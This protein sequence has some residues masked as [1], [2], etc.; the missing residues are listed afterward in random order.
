MTCQKRPPSPACLGPGTARACAFCQAIAQKNELTKRLTSRQQVVE[1]VYS[2]EVAQL[3]DGS[4]PQWNVH[5]TLS[6]EPKGSVLT[7]KVLVH[8]VDGSGAATASV[9][10]TWASMVGAVW[11]NK[12]QLTVPV[13]DT[14]M[15]VKAAETLTRTVAFTLEWTDSATAHAYDVTCNKSMTTKEFITHFEGLPA[16]ERADLVAWWRQSQPTLRDYSAADPE[17]K[18]M[19]YLNDVPR[20]ATRHGTPH[21]GE[22]GDKDREAVQ[23]E[24]G[25]AI[26]LPDEYLT[27]N[28]WL[29]DPGGADFVEVPLDLA[30]YNLAPFSSNSLM[31]NTMSRSGSKLFSR[32]FDLLAKDFEDLVRT[33]LAVG[34]HVKAGSARV[35]MIA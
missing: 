28:Y 25:H 22:W 7:V 12:A 5:Y 11:N 10:G 32:H 8:V 34:R 13:Y 17:W 3:C 1:K 24:F 31:N 16:D 20:D 26:G 6:T 14:A 15:A 9:R 19:K 27:T 2:R 23:H 35:Q 21:I 30:I 4:M 18:K 33:N 29:T